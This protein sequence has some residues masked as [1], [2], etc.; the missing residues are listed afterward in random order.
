MMRLFAWLFV[1]GLASPGGRVHAQDGPEPRSRFET[2]ELGAYA[3]LSVTPGDAVSFPVVLGVGV[4]LAPVGALVLEGSAGG[5][6][7][8]SQY[9]S[10]LL[11]ARLVRKG[12]FALSLAAGAR[13]QNTELKQCENDECPYWP[14]V[15]LWWIPVEAAVEWRPWRGLTVRPHT[16]VFAPIGPERCRGNVWRESSSSWEPVS[17]SGARCKPD[18]ALYLGVSI[19]WSLQFGVR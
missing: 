18:P 10:A 17:V 15:E 19:G 3:D 7:E 16:G 9:W 11:R 8:A 13:R 2:M 5:F 6:V 4:A 14:S 1:I 12:P